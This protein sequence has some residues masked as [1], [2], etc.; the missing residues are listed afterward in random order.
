MSPWRL[1]LP[2]STI[3]GIDGSGEQIAEGLPTVESQG[4]TN[5]R[6]LHQSIF[7]LLLPKLA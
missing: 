5:I 6:L 4:M 1:A 3:A 7:D 2:V